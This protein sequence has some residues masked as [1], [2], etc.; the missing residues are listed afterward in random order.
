MT[1][2]GINLNSIPQRIPEIK[3]FDRFLFDRF[4]YSKPLSISKP[5]FTSKFR[6]QKYL[7]G[8]QISRYNKTFF[9]KFNSF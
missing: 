1:V 2:Y 6:I 7:V 8:I 4:G 3:G 5:F 9:D